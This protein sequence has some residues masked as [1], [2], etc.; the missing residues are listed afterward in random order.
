[1][2]RADASDLIAIF[3]SLYDDLIRMLTART[4][5]PERAAD[6][7]QDTYFRL[8]G[9]QAAG[10]RVAN[11]RAYVFRV[12]H[13]LA[14]DEGRKLTR[15][16]RRDASEDEAAVL[17][18]PEPLADAA[19]LAKERLRLLDAALQELPSNARQA[20]LLNRVEGLTQA[21]IARRLGVSESMVIK[22]VAQALK[23]CRAWRRRIDS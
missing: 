7:V 3:Q 8:A 17:R 9:V 16:I 6:I 12:A 13:N 19:L 5:D 22:Y 14:I 23:H 21:E 18:D 20:L 2:G 4:G 15:A 11:P 1:M 10:E